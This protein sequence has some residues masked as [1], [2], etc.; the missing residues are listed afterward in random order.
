MYQLR[1]QGPGVIECSVR[2]RLT[3]TDH[4]EV[5]GKQSFACDSGHV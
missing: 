5:E 2:I 3:S 4:E 1:E